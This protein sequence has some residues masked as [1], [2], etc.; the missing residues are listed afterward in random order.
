MTLKE[1]NKTTT[2]LGQ[3]VKEFQT[4]T[5]SAY[6]TYEL[7]KE[8][9]KRWR[10]KAKKAS[11][12]LGKGKQKAAAEPSKMSSKEATFNTMTY[13]FHSL[14]DYVVNIKM[15]GTC[16]SYSTEPVSLPDMISN[17]PKS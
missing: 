10:A 17:I 13:K 11:Q 1:L 16:D 15:Y 9:E 2:L 12:L 3:K 4:K 8:T 7:P 6:R 14:D 5:C